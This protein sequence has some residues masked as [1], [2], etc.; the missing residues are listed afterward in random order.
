MVEEKRFLGFVDSLTT[1]VMIYSLDRSEGGIRFPSEIHIWFNTDKFAWEKGKVAGG[2]VAKAYDA[3]MMSGGHWNIDLNNADVGLIVIRE[4][5]TMP[6]EEDYG[7]DRVV[8][9]MIAEIL[10]NERVA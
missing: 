9:D 10:K 4:N 1:G 5:P 3:T 6:D 8:S 7:Q 2:Y